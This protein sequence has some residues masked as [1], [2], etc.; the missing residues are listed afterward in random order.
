[1]RISIRPSGLFGCMGLAGCLGSMA[2]FAVVVAFVGG[3]FFLVMSSFKSSPVYTLAMDA[4]RADSRVVQ[5]LG[6]PIESGWL[7]S[8]SLSEQGLSGDANLSIPI[9]GPRKGATLFASARKGDGVWKFYTLAVQV[10][11]QS[12]LII[13]EH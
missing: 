5:A 4:A 6:T 11:G 2:V 1:M 12:S 8:G 3:I 13:L 7:I 10:D 9:S